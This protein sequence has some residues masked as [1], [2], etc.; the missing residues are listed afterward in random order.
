MTQLSATS[1]DIG[2][3]R[4][5][6][7]AV[8]KRARR[9]LLT[10]GHSYCVAVNRRL[11]HEM[12]REGGEDWEVTAVAPEFFHGDLRPIRTERMDSIPARAPSP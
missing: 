10:I 1:V 2:V 4:M 11:A 5:P 3:S 6:S 12:A 8:A 7:P 9:R